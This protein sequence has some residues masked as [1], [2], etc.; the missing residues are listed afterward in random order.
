M[1][2][3]NLRSAGLAIVP[4]M[5]LAACSSGLI[6]A[7]ETPP[8]E[9]EELKRRVVEYQKRATV[10]ELEGARLK[11]EVAR[12]EAELERTK[13]APS[14][15]PSESA[16]PAVPDAP[17]AEAEPEPTTPAVIGLDQEIEET[18]LEDVPAA[19]PAT[20]E[21]V[22]VPEPTAQSPTGGELAESAA[23]DVPPGTGAAEPEALVEVV[24]A[25]ASVEAQALYDEGYTLFHQKRYADAEARFKRYLE[26]HPRTDLADNALFWIGESRYARGEFSSA[27]EAFSGTVE[28]Y[29]QSNKVGDALFKA[30]KCLEALGDAQQAQRTYQEVIGRYPNSSAAAQAR[31]R[32]EALR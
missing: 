4:A 19:S 15:P 27:L 23:G 30:G 18:D 25:V 24:M 16:Q 9:V 3:S 10:A 28:R 12:L 1:R 6:G 5:L 29:P 17:P 14:L 32:L 2:A 26:I 21:P 7:P 22:A 31:D 8:Q 11:R 20:D 13:Q